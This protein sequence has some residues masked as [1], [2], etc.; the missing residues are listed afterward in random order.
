LTVLLAALVIW[1]GPAVAAASPPA[2]PAALETV[3]RAGGAL[4]RDGHALDRS[5]L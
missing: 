4:V 3:L 2:D 5:L 1:A